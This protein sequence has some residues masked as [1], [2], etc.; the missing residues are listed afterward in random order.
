V[1]LPITGHME[2]IRP[3]LGF[4][5]CTSMNLGSRTTSAFIIQRDRGPLPINKEAPPIRATVDRWRKNRTWYD[6]SE[7]EIYTTEVG[8]IKVLESFCLLILACTQTQFH[9]KTIGQ[10]LHISRL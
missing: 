10:L 5:E 3:L 1:G 6:E 4:C 8:F 7:V 2:G 9:W